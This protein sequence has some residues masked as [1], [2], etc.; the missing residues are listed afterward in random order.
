MTS[1]TILFLK[2]SDYV[3]LCCKRDRETCQ[4]LHISIF[5]TD[6]PAHVTKSALRKQRLLLFSQTRKS[7]APWAAGPAGSDRVRRT[8]ESWGQHPPRRAS[9]CPS[10]RTL[11]AAFRPELSFR[12]RAL[13]SPGKA[14]ASG[15]LR[16]A[17]V[18]RCP[19]TAH[20]SPAPSAAGTAPLSPPRSP[21]PA[22]M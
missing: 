15:R 11:A 22:V 9:R 4:L 8:G 7:K 20:P 5:Q 21:F 16:R 19:G 1:L 13:T 6:C 14:A 3:L 2:I 18:L 12:P 10:V 17:P